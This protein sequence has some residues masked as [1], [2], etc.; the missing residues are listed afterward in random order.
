[1]HWIFLIGSITFQRFPVSATIGLLLIVGAETAIPASYLAPFRRRKGQK[2]T[3]MTCQNVL[4]NIPKWTA[5]QKTYESSTSIRGSSPYDDTI[6][7][8]TDILPLFTY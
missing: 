1:M 8:S 6:Q 4:P 3:Q 7:T 2:N 5:K